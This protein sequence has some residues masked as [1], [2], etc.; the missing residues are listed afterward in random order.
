MTKKLKTPTLTTPNLV[1]Q[2]LEP[3]HLNSLQKHFNN[4]NII[5]NLNDNIPWPYPDNGTQ[6]YYEEILVPR[7]KDGETHAWAITEKGQDEAIGILE[8]RTQPPTGESNRGF[9]LAEPYWGRGYMAEAVTAGNDFYFF[10]IKMDEMRLDNFKSNIGSRRVKEKTGTTY[11][12]TISQPWRGEEIEIE[13][14]TLNAAAWQAF[15]QQQTPKRGKTP[16]P[17]LSNFKKGQ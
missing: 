15:R 7:I 8:Y 1:L 6:T 16:S 9:W 2:P 14:W 13:V 5:K 12:K 11:I 10:E 3:K 17:S 4:W